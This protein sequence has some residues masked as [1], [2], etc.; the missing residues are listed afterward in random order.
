LIHR[1]PTAL[2]HERSEEVARCFPG[3]AFDAAVSRL[4]DEA[5]MPITAVI[6]AALA[7]AFTRWTGQSYLLLELSHHSR[8]SEGSIDGINTVGWVNDTVP[9]IIDGRAVEAAIANASAQI[10][11]LG[12]HGAAYSYVRFLAPKHLGDENALLRRAQISLNLLL[13]ANDPQQMPEGMSVVGSPGLA[14]IGRRVHPISGGAVRTPDSLR[15]SLDFD[16]RAFAP[17][18][19]AELVDLWALS[20]SE[21]VRELGGGELPTPAGC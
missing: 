18:S 20:I 16:P 17:G 8:P 7:R 4:A 5:R 2:D 13:N 21:A 6:T 15:I 19:V 11:E 1:D 14:M 10:N 12:R 9:L 3:E